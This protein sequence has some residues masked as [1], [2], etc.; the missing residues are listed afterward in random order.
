MEFMAH[1]SART[2]R[3]V[4]GCITWEDQTS[5]LWFLSPLTSSHWILPPT[6][7]LRDLQDPY[8]FPC[9]FTENFHHS[10]FPNSVS[11]SSAKLSR[12]GHDLVPHDARLRICEVGTRATFRMPHDLLD[13]GGH[14]GQ[15]VSP[16]KTAIEMGWEGVNWEE[17]VGDIFWFIL[18]NWCSK[19]HWILLRSLCF[20][21]PATPLKF[22]VF[23]GTIRSTLYHDV[24]NH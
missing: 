19:N 18:K 24:L 9:F 20:C 8:P 12:L 23:F 11:E 10:P 7:S 15:V 2:L 22:C 21:L 13:D 4:W 1:D 16:K 6:P 3:W 5:L 17:T 14:G